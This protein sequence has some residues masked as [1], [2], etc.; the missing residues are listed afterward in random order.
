M[1]NAASTGHL[2]LHLA[3]RAAREMSH[4]KRKCAERCIENGDVLVSVLE[5]LTLSCIMKLSQSNR[6]LYASEQTQTAAADAFL[7]V[8]ILVERASLS[9]ENRINRLMQN[10]RE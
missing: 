7:D 9:N 8:P 5:C 2:A 6:T 3:E 10:A 4:T 1:S